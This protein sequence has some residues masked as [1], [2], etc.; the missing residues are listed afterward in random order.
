MHRWS[1]TDVINIRRKKEQSY[2]SLR[3]TYHVLFS[4]CFPKCLLFELIP[5]DVL[6]HLALVCATVQLPFGDGRMT[7]AFAFWGCAF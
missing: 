7:G 6:A 1:V 3:L 5:R 4:L 2:F